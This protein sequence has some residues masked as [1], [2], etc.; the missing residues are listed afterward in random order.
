MSTVPVTMTNQ[1]W[2]DYFYHR[3]R[4]LQH[5]SLEDLIQRTVDVLSN[6]PTLRPDGRIGLLPIDETGQYWFTLFCNIMTE[7]ELRGE[8]LPDGFLTNAPVPKPTWP[9][10]P[11]GLVT[12]ESMNV[13]G[14][15]LFKYGEER[16]LRPILEKGLI[17]LAPASFYSDPSLNLAQKDD[18]LEVSILANPI[19]VKVQRVDQQTLED[20]GEPIHPIGNV[21]FTLQYPSDY[22]V[23]CLASSYDL[24]LYDDF[25]SDSCLVI[26]D[27]KR[28][29]EKIFAA[30]EEKVPKW[31]GC[32]TFVSYYDPLRLE[33]MPSRVFFHKHF[34]YSYQKEYRIVLRPPEPVGNL[35]PLFIEIG[36][37]EEYCD[38]IKVS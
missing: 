29:V 20:E 17:R 23:F 38:L 21:N 33:K 27:P 2:I 35:S 28:F 6:Y 11:R 32:A 16:Y 37:L 4:Y 12:P 26:R 25:P 9:S 18:E 1:Q 34:R 30:F 24:R 8:T 31:S 10:P 36:S 19:R 14:D 5:L 15:Y 13:V 3:D 7:L 22:Y